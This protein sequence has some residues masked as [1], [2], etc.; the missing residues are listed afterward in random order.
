MRCARCSR[1]RA[2]VSFL[3]LFL[4]PRFWTSCHIGP[5]TSFFT[6]PLFLQCFNSP[7]FIPAVRL[8]GSRWVQPSRLEEPRW[9]GMRPPPGRPRNPDALIDRVAGE[10]SLP[11]QGTGLKTSPGGDYFNLYEM[12]GCSESESF[13][14]L[15]P[16]SSPFGP[17]FYLTPTTSTAHDAMPRP[18]GAHRVLS[19]RR[20]CLYSVGG[21]VSLP[22]SHRHW[23][24]IV[25]S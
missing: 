6:K 21:L 7:L 14:V 23:G 11:D 9:G 24:S 2:E 10:R 4:F 22:T 25:V 15:R 12:S 16:Y 8:M 20:A 19:P 17:F 13:L 18:S 3:F 5:F 1:N